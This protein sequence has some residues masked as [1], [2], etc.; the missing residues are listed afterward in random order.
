MESIQKE[1]CWRACECVPCYEAKNF[2]DEYNFFFLDICCAVHAYIFLFCQLDS[3]TIELTIFFFSFH[4]RSSTLYFLW[5][6]KSVNFWPA[7]KSERRRAYYLSI[8]LSTPEQGY[9]FVCTQKTN[10]WSKTSY[11]KV[12]Y[13][14]SISIERRRLFG[15]RLFLY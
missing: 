6:G 14:F 2:Y 4:D 10:L 9:Y 7:G 1:G 5:A 3:Y 12:N 8:H 15:W 11:K 13:Y